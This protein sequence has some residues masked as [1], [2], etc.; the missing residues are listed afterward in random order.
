M[1]GLDALALGRELGIDAQLVEGRR[2]LA[3][4]LARDGDPAELVGVVGGPVLEDDLAGLVKQDVDDR[5][6][7][8][9]RAESRR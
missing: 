9:R 5:A 4:C 6:L 2:R 7:G 3:G 1:I 8:R